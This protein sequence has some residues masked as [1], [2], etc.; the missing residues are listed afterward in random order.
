M[1]R[2]EANSCRTHWGVPKRARTISLSD[3]AWD[4][5]SSYAQANDLNRSEVLERLIRRINARPT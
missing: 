5:L 4:L 2:A 3:E 1:R